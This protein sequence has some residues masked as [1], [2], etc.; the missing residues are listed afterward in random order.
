VRL[1]RVKAAASA[2]VQLVAAWIVFRR[3]D[4]AS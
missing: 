4:V 1:S 2:I 3:R